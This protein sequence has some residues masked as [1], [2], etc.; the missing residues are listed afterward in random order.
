MMACIK[1]SVKDSV[2]HLLTYSTRHRPV[3][4]GLWLPAGSNQIGQADV[5]PNEMAPSK[6]HQNAIKEVVD[7]KI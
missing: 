2:K 5:V 3:S 7:I 1:D 6:R 4:N